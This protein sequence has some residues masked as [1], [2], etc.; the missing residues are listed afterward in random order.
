MQARSTV[1]IAGLQSP[2]GSVSTRSLPV[3]ATS[4][5]S[6]QSG[7]GGPGYRCVMTEHPRSTRET[8]INPTSHCALAWH[9]TRS[10]SHSRHPRHQRPRL[11]RPL[12]APHRDTSLKGVRLL[13]QRP[14]PDPVWRSLPSSLFGLLTMRYFSAPTA[15]ILSRQACFRRLRGWTVAMKQRPLKSPF[16]VR[17]GRNAQRPSRRHTVRLHTLCGDDIWK[18]TGLSLPVKALCSQVCHATYLL[19]IRH[20][21]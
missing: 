19:P 1:W 17:R 5:G 18:Q 3:A 20:R 12:M 21:C 11:S 2:P 16:S 10:L 8:C 14:C 9:Q 13:S 15:H 7:S 6:S 4:R